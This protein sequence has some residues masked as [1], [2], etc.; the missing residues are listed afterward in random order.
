MIRLVAKRA[1]IAVVTLWLLVSAVFCLVRFTGDPSTMMEGAS[2]PQYAAALRQ[3][4]GL[5]R[6]YVVQ[7]GLYLRNL[8]EGDFGSSFQKGLP[9]TT[10]YFQSLPTSLVLGFSAFLISLAVGVP[11]GIVSALKVNT[12]WDRV[13]TA[14]AL[15]GLSIPNFVVG[16][17]LIILFGVE[18]NWLP[19]MGAGDGPFDWRHLVLPAFALGWYF[20]GNM[21]RVT[22]SSMLD[23]LRSDYVRL[24]RIKGVPEWVV[25]VKHALVNALIPIVTLA[26]LNLIIMVNVAVPIEVVFGRPGIGTL[27]FDGM[28]NRDFPLVQ[29]VVLMIAIMVLILNLLTDLLYA[30][31]DPRIRVG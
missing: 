23:V 28:M 5:D 14:F 16:L 3:R 13:G 11:L 31:L 25:L 18:L 29:G 27:L 17:V 2:D 12:A 30:W 26:G 22:R 8:A 4:W 21:V 24:V 9:V 19:V 20:S 15:T 10:L 6:P 1:G 7:Y